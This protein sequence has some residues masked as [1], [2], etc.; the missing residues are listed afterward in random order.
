MMNPAEFANIAKA[1]NDFWWYRGMRHIMYGLLDPVAG[2]RKF[3]RVLEAGCGTGHF[4]RALAARYRWP[5]FPLD[6]GWEGLKHGKG[7]GIDRLTQGDIQSLPY[8]DG[9]FDAVVSMDVIV[10]M[11]RGE[12]RKP[13]RE[14]HRVLKPGGFLALRASALDILRSHHS[15]FAM[16]RQ[17]FTR[18]RLIQLAENTGFNVLRCTY[19]NSLLLPVA[20]LKFRVVEP[21]LGGQPESG[22]RPVASWLDKLLYGPLKA[23]SK[24]LTTGLNLPLGQSLILLAERR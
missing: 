8:R 4:A 1:E 15:R 24:L 14:F 16:E 19:A 18:S 7:L 11:P 21:L 13:M 6:L 10:H 2:Q 9:V 12:E 23:E 3:G 17:R 5:M 22:V 20:L